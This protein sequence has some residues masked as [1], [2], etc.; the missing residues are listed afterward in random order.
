MFG[1][2]FSIIGSQLGSQQQS[3]LAAPNWTRKVNP[4]V[5][6]TAYNAQQAQANAAAQQYNAAIH[7]GREYNVSKL[8]E[9]LE[10]RENN[11][12]VK[13]AWETYQMMLK[14]NRK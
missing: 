5:T 13:D 2:I 7:Y 12:G 14:L 10:L 3:P 1:G 4:T 9:E 6:S 11:P 8:E